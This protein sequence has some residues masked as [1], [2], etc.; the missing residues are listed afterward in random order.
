M[1]S[2]TTSTGPSGAV[3]TFNG[4]GTTTVPVTLTR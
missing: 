4:S 1:T 2:Q 3:S